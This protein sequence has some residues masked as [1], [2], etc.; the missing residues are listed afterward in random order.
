MTGKQRIAKAMRREKADRVPVFCQLAIGHYMLNSGK[1]AWRLWFSPQD[2]SDALVALA[3]R[4]GFD[5]VLVNLPGRPRDWEAQ[6]ASVEEGPGGTRIAWKGGG[7]S[8]SPDDDNVHYQGSGRRPSLDEVDPGCLY[9]VEPHCITEVSYPFS[10]DFAPPSSAFGPTFFPDYQ[11]DSLRLTVQKGGPSLHV[12]SEIFSPFTQLMELL[13][14]AEGLI[15]LMDDP[16]KCEDILAALSAGAAELA[17]LQ[18]QAGSDAVLVS[19]AFAGAGFLSLE[20][21]RRFVLPYE[22]AIVTRIHR[23]TGAFAYV[24]SCGSIGDRIGAMAEA[25][26]DG[27]DTMDPPPLGNTDIGSVKKEFGERLFLK[28]NLDPVNILLNGEAE[29]IR[30][31]AA[32]L[33]ATA[34]RD[35]GYILSTACSVS[36][37]TDPAKIA[38]LAEASKRHPY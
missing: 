28:G 15:A 16:D 4:Y 18:A 21:Y 14:Y 36:P 37:R 24:H 6:V 9:Y 30:S 32:E 12:S 33:I 25:G 31:K 20:Q 38:L 5:G 35:G 13:G 26:Y 10:F 23:E 11:L 3:G 2:F 8:L 29:V 22:K 19:S 27:I 17:V 34:G 7:C 1:T